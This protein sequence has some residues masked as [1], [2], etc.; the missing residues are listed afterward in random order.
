MQQ[1]HYVEYGDE[2][3][4]AWTLPDLQLGGGG[5]IF[6]THVEPWPFFS[7]SLAAI[8]RCLQN[9]TPIPS[10]RFEKLHFTTI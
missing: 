1:R 5:V 4:I 10:V 3:L 8:Y 9:I 7:P 6:D 2:M